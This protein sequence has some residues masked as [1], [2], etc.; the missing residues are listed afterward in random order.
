MIAAAGTAASIGGSI[1]SFGAQNKAAWEQRAYNAKVEAQQEKYRAELIQYQNVVYQQDVDH[2]HKQLDYQ[3][4]EFKRQDTL[5]TNARESIQRNLFA[6]YATLLQRAVEE[7]MSTTFQTVQNDKSVVAARAKGQVTA[8]ARGVE[9]SSV[10]QLMNDIS[11][12]RGDNETILQLNR[13][14]TARQLNLEALGLKASADQQL[15]NL[16]IQTFQP[17]GPINPPSPISPVQPAA[18]VAGPNRGAMMANV[19][20]AVTTGMSNYATWSG[21]TMKQAF[22]FKG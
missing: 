18:P 6:Q 16:P 13:S 1:M 7:N 19:V 22:S 15:Y 5:V 11:R 3:E 4:S 2:G 17:A 8:D 9:G 21:Q 12:E 14:A 10:E 20:G